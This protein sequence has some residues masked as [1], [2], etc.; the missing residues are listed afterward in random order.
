MVCHPHYVCFVLLNLQTSFSG[1]LLT[2][3]YPHGYLKILTNDNLPLL[4]WGQK[5]LRQP[6][7]GISP[8]EEQLVSK[9]QLLMEEAISRTGQI[10]ACCQVTWNFS[11]TVS[12]TFVTNPF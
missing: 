7:V 11:C 10:V 9:C 2:Y 12:K 8:W 1:H 5:L 6:V 4:F 3:L